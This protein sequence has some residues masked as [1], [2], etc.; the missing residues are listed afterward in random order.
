MDRSEPGTM[1]GS[2]ILVQSVD[3]GD[4]RKFSVLL[5]HVV[6]AGAGIV[7][8][9]NAEVLDL[10]GLLLMDLYSTHSPFSHHPNDFLHL[11]PNNSQA[12]FCQRTWF[13]DTISPALF[14][15]FL[16][17]LRKYQN[18]DL[19]TTSFGANSLMR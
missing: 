6:G 14:L 3:S 19:A 1:P 4:A 17:F 15:T 9:P 11:G 12:H 10:E 2:H 7:S 16:N 18:R 13:N 8:D 5:V